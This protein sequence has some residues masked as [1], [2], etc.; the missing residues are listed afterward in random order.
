MAKVAVFAAVL[1]ILLITGM[2]RAVRGRKAKAIQFD[3]DWTQPSHAQFEVPSWD[4]PIMT[5]D[6]TF[7]TQPLPPVQTEQIPQTFGQPEFTPQAHAEPAFI[8]VMPVVQR[9]PM[10]IAREK[11]PHWD[12]AT[13]QG[14]F[15]GGWNVEQLE[16]WVIQDQQTIQP[17][18]ETIQ[19]DEPAALASVV[20]PTP[21]VVEAEAQSWCCGNCGSWIYASAGFCVNCGQPRL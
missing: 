3:D 1:V 7:Q 21:A 15:D 12:D 20:E 19:V 6:T 2:V 5:Q 4:P 9:S 11:F 14:Y 13:I 18:Q 8:P 16:E 17:I 10:D